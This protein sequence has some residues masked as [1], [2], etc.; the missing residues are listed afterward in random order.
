VIGHPAPFAFCG[1]EIY[2]L[3]PKGETK[4]MNTKLKI[5]AVLL[6][7]ALCILPVAAFHVNLLTAAIALCGIAGVTVT[8]AS[9]QDGSGPHQAY[10]GGTTAPTIVQSETVNAVVAT[11]SFADSET[12]ALIS[13]N[14]QITA[15]QLAALQPY[16]QCYIAT[17]PTVLPI[18]S[19]ALTSG[20][21]VTV[22]KTSLEGSGGSLVVI[23]RRPYSA[24]Q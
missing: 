7:L 19:F 8:Y 10:T 9:F 1:V 4:T 18:L 23:I 16:I 13:H 14:M 20:N 11:V 15:A 2:G 22:T 6:A 17:G 24:S 12:T 5:G 21:V 3:R